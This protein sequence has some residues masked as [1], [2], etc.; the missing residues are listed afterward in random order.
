MNK[1]IL[2]GLFLT[3]LLSTTFLSA[4][5][6][7]KNS[8]IVVR[9][10]PVMNNQ[11]CIFGGNFLF[12]HLSCRNA[13]LNEQQEVKVESYYDHKSG[14]KITKESV[15]QSTYTS[16]NQLNNQLSYTFS[17]TLNPYINVD[18]FD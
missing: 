11:N 9:D 6:I 2:A 1:K 10:I 7:E 5:P 4:Y 18:Y 17:G 12:F 16:A 13:F 8:K 14:L 3:I 15:V